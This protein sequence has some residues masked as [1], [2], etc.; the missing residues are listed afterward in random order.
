MTHLFCFYVNYIVHILYNMLFVLSNNFYTLTSNV[1]VFSIVR[2]KNQS[3]GKDKVYIF[4][5]LK[6]RPCFCI[7][8]MQFY[9]ILCSSC[10]ANEAPTVIYASRQRRM[11]ERNLRNKTLF[12]FV[13]N[14]FKTYA[15]NHLRGYKNV[16]FLFN[17]KY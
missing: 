6:C 14:N 17:F 4:N 15:K 10:E 1:I 5:Q 13:K 9:L 3:G 16:H 12:I 7:F 11:L 2:L 8:L